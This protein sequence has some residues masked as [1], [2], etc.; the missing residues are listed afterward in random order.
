M[1]SLLNKS[2]V[3]KRVLE[4]TKYR[5]HDFTRVSNQFMID[6]EVKLNKIIQNSVAQH[7]SK[8]K[9]IDQIM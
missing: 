3:R 4:Y 5:T 8:G 9:T 1:K 7:P 6:L 2:E